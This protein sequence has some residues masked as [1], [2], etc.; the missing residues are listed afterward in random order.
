MDFLNLVQRDVCH[1]QGLVLGPGPT[2]HCTICQKQAMAI[3]DY[4]NQPHEDYF[5]SS[6]LAQAYEAWTGDEFVPMSFP[7]SHIEGIYDLIVVG[8]PLNRVRKSI[9]LLRALNAPFTTEAHVQL[10]E[11]MRTLLPDFLNIIYEHSHAESTDELQAL[12]ALMKSMHDILS[13]KDAI[14]PF[15]TYFNVLVPFVQKCLTD[16]QPLPAESEH[17]NL[18]VELHSQL[19]RSHVI[20]KTFSR[21]A[22]PF[23]VLHVMV[24]CYASSCNMEVVGNWALDFLARICRGE[25][26]WGQYRDCIFIKTMQKLIQGNIHYN[27]RQGNYYQ[28]VVRPIKSGESKDHYSNLWIPLHEVQALLKKKYF[29]PNTSSD[30]MDVAFQHAFPAVL[31][32]DYADQ[33]GFMMGYNH[34]I[35]TVNKR[36]GVLPK[37][38]FK[39]AR[40]IHDVVQR[41]VG[42][43][44]DF[45]D[46]DSTKKPI[47]NMDMLKLFFASDE[48]FQK[49]IMQVVHL[50]VKNDDEE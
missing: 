18:A 17:P 19:L 33:L 3:Y 37:G 5:R 48:D 8:Q 23:D 15:E 41:F 28:L 6:Q 27:T 24:C 16:W 49:E 32:T 12:H 40:V 35:M 44:R 10:T 14:N 13:V 21:Y 7:L 26:Y 9:R 25:F 42:R 20:R 38:A 47:W 11:D 45:D 31:F 43:I 34:L 50:L 30:I 36:N 39:K 29:L 1:V 46:G 2:L 4:I 22:I